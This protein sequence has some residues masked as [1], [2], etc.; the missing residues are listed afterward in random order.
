MKSREQ[1]WED[2]GRHNERQRIAQRY[3]EACRKL[4]A[5]DIDQPPARIIGKAQKILGLADER[6][7]PNDYTSALIRVGA[8]VLAAYT[9]ETERQQSELLEIAKALYGKMSGAVVDPGTPWD[10]LTD[11]E[12]LEMAARVADILEERSK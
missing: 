8:L 4:S 9:K 7:P 2:Q 3:I 11:A 6:R 5:A 12:R 1:V 10:K